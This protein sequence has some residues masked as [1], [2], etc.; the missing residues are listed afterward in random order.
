[1][2][3]HGSIAGSH[4]N[5]TR[6]SARSSVVTAAATGAR[7]E[8][9]LAAYWRAYRNQGRSHRHLSLCFVCLWNE[10]GNDPVCAVF[11]Q[12]HVCPFSSAS[13]MNDRCHTTIASRYT[14]TPPHPFAQ[15]DFEVPVAAYSSFLHHSFSLMTDYKYTF[16]LLCAGSNLQHIEERVIQRVCTAMHLC[17]SIIVVSY[18]YPIRNRRLIG[19]P[20]P[21]PSW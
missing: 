10:G 21:G 17:T 5:A 14:P 7:R 6:A 13:S 9:T 2:A 8:A 16:S 11:S 3:D 20:P 15:L 19:E 18:L 12:E 4:E 1:M